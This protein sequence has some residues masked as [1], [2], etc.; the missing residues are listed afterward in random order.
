M[1]GSSSTTSCCWPEWQGVPLLRH[2][3]SINNVD[4]AV[5]LVDVGDADTCF[6]ALGVDHPQHAVM[7]CDGKRLALHSLQRGFST[8]L[9]GIGQEL[10]GTEAS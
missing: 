5:G 7:E 4:D 2:Q 3:H 10:G 6:A 9:P 8:V 1:P